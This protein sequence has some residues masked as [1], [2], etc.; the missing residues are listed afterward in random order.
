MQHTEL[1][2][3]ALEVRILA[4]VLGK[5]ADRDLETRLS[6]G[7]SDLTPLQYEVLRLLS[8]GPLTLSEISR[9]MVLSPT[10]LVPVIDALERREYVARGIDP[11]DRRRSPRSLT[12]TGRACLAG[13]AS[14][15]G[16]RLISKALSAMGPEKAEQLCV[17]L[18]ELVAQA[19]DNAELVNNIQAVA[20]HAVAAPGGNGH[21]PDLV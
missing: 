6:Q 5:L 14:V 16:P 15:R 21:V 8:N 10:T 1:F 17:L 18:R 12:E 20:Q 13:L 7:G 3:T 2:A 9:R 4:N 19:S 11:L